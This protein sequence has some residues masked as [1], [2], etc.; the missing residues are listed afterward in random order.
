VN[1]RIALGT[2]LTVGAAF[3]LT[4][5]ASAAQF[6]VDTNSDSVLTACTGA[7]ADCS[8]RGAITDSN[9]TSTVTD[10]ITFAS[11]ISGQTITLPNP[12]YAGAL[13]QITDAV[14][15]DGPGANLLTIDG[16][17]NSGIFR[18]A[19]P[20]GE[21][22]VIEGLT[23]THGMQLSG[24]AIEDFT[25]KLTVQDSVITGNTATTIGGGIHEYGGFEN[26]AQTQIIGSTISG[27][28]TSSS[29]GDG[30]G[31]A[32][33]YG[34][35]TIIRSTIANNHA[36]AGPLSRGGGVY[37]DGVELIDSTVAG[38]SAGVGGGLETSD[39]DIRNSIIANNTAFDAESGHDIWATGA[40][41]ITARFSLIERYS[42]TITDAV[43]R[44]NI[45]GQDP[46]L[47]ALAGNGGAT[48]TMR[49]L[50]SS[51]AVDCGSSSATTDQRGSARPVDLAGRT[52]SNVAG[53]DASDIGAFELTGSA[54]GSCPN[55]IGSS[56]AGPQPAG[57]QPAP[58]P[59]STAKK[60]KKKKKKHKKHASAAKKK[61]KKCKKKKKKR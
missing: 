21:P 12:G 2:G 60:C 49:L 19:P 1:R 29:S 44:S 35:G 46:Q 52:N 39:T 3:G 31:I 20:A 18:I 48:P 42:A 10:V 25:A 27:N 38:N 26:G 30:G 56:G 40:S 37:A 16:N 58:Q 53:A 59:G 36:G 14:T 15:I 34:L 57:P 50:S 61:H 43:A 23:L 24:A 17:N 6:Q 11:A 9:A 33:E 41:T 7:A 51:P 55:F 32:G 45:L 5:N 8:L 22:V 4:A 13:P 47:A 54:S 28:T